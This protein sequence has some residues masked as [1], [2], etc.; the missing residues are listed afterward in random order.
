MTWI[1]FVIAYRRMSDERRRLSRR[2]L[3]T[4]TAALPES[5]VLAPSA[6]DEAMKVLGEDEALRLLDILTESQ[7]D[8]VSLRVVA[9]LTLNETAAVMGKPISAVKALQ[10]RAIAALRRALLQQ[11]VSK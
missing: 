1:V 2:P 9:G 5:P 11:G 4:P 6:E 10:R 8:V 3:E 7:R